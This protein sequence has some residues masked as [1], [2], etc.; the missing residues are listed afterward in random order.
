MVFVNSR[1]SLS[2]SFFTP[3]AHTVSVPTNE[4]LYVPKSGKHRW[5]ILV[6]G[7]GDQSDCSLR[8]SVA[9]SGKALALWRW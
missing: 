1:D 5:I 2:L 4:L 3:P 9:P 7:A 8:D 6:C